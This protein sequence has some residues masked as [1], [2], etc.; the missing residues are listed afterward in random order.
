[1]KIK[2]L[3]LV[4]IGFMA[5]VVLMGFQSTGGKNNQ[6]TK[7]ST[8]VT[9]PDSQAVKTTYSDQWQ[10]FKSESEQKIQDN[11]KSIAAF[12]EKMKE[13][14]TKMEAKYNKEIAKLEKANRRMK[15]KLEEYKDA[16]KSA[17]ADFKTRFSNDM[18]KIGKAVKD[19][20][21]D[22]DE[23]QQFKS[24]SEQRIQDNEKSIAAFKEKM[25]RSGTKMEAKYNKGI[26]DLEKANRRMKRKLEEYKDAGKTAWADFKTRFSND[27]DKIGKALKDLTSGND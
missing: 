19:L 8:G 4:V 21:I 1:M 9:K 2:I 12:K 13:S 7:E 10:Q 11:E 27:M 15:R 3:T 25:K 20:T 14:G 24:E 26:A 23:W 22:S 18:D 6:G 17:W 5:S 16:G